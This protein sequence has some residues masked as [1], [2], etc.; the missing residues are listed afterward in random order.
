[1]DEPVIW[2]IDPLDD[3]NLADLETSTLNNELVA[4]VDERAGGIIAY[5]LTAHADQVLA[6]LRQHAERTNS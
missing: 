2:T 6:A 5:A 4:I 1:M 3:D